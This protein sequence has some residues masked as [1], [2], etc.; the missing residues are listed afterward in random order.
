MIRGRNISLT[1]SKIDKYKRIEKRFSLPT[2]DP[3]NQNT[4]ENSSIKG[5]TDSLSNLPP[6]HV[7]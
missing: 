3:Y 2:F 5:E 1:D 7:K 6:I 4:E